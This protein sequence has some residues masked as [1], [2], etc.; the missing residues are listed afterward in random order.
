MRIDVTRVLPYN[1]GNRCPGGPGGFTLTEV[2]VAMGVLAIGAVAALSLFAAAAATQKKAVDRVASARLA[3]EVIA[4]VESRLAGDADPADLEVLGGEIES[5]PGYEFDVHLTPQ[6]D[7]P[8]EVL[9][10]VT[11]RWKSGGRDRD[12]V[13][14]TILLQSL[15]ERDILGG[16]E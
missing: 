16:G 15:G 10:E 14:R 6:D 4:L 2:L 9:L 12:A 13:Y 7:P 1:S 5:F 8:L 3:E 11:V